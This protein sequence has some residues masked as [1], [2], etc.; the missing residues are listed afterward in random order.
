MAKFDKRYP[1]GILLVLIGS[2][3]LLKNL[4]LLPAEIPA[5]VFTWKM[6]LVVI[7]MYCLIFR[8]KWFSGLLFT[9]IGA[10]FL[11]PEILGI[12]LL[13][14]V[15]LWPGIII[16]C[17]LFVLFARPSKKKKKKYYSEF[18]QENSDYMDISAIAS[19]N[20]RQVSS[21]DFKGGKI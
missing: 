9:G 21:Y 17:G 18:K 4:N 3:L 19:G 20:S 11:V 13:D 14:A 10:Y 2:V 6:L 1:F 7:G 5:Y 12:P 15:M 8:G 16:F